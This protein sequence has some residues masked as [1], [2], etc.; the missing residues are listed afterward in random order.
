LIL[1][2]AS[3]GLIK[4][5]SKSDSIKT[6][7]PKKKETKFLKSIEAKNK[8]ERESP[9]TIQSHWNITTSFGEEKEKLNE[10]LVER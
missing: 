3:Y 6:F 7:N 5:A 9:L 10:Y 4:S 2:E 1:D 8:S